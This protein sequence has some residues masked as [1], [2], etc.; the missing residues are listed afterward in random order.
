MKSVSV[1]VSETAYLQ[2]KTLAS[3]RGRPV[4]ELIRQAMDDYLER[5]KTRQRP[6]LDRAPH[7][8]GRLLHP[9]TREEVLD[10][11]VSRS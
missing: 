2:M 1:H 10:E 4:A 7:A 3:E 8:S 6:L 9:W 11:M 5:E